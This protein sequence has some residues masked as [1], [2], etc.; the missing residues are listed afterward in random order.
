MVLFQV[1]TAPSNQQAKVADFGV[2]RPE[3]LLSYFRVTY[4][5]TLQF[6]GSDTLSVR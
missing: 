6:P 5:A 2:A 4:Y 1:P 3:L